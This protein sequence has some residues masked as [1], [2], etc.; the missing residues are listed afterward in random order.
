MMKGALLSSGSHPLQ[1]EGRNCRN[2]RLCD[3]GGIRLENGTYLTLTRPFSLNSC[4]AF[5]TD[6]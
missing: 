4:Q 2:K 5:A 1:N 6:D 3:K